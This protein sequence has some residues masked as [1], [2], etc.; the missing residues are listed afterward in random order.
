MHRIILSILFI[1]LFVQSYS[2]KVGLVLSGGGA[3]GISHI[4][5]IKVLEDHN[6]P[7][8]Y[9]AGT[10][11]GA[12]VAG[13]YAAGYSPEEMVK[14][15]ESDEFRLWSTGRLDKDE[16]YYFKKKDELPDWIK[17]DITKK[18]DKIK[19]IFPM[20]FIPERQMDFAFMQLMAQ[21]TAACEGDFDKMMVPFRCVATDIYHSTGLVLKQ[22]DLGE[23]IRASMTVPFVFKPIK[24]DGNVL[25]DGG[26]VNNFPAD[27]MIQEFNPD[28]IIGHKVSNIGAKDDMDDIVGQI[29][30]IITQKTNYS[31]PDSLGILL[32]SSLND[33]GLLDFQKV[34]YIYGKGVE[35]AIKS[36][37]SIE[38][39]IKRRVPVDSVSARRKEFNSKKPPFLFNNVQVEGVEDELNRKYIIESIKEKDKV[40]DLKDLRDAYFKL[41]T[42]EHIKS[43][44]PLAYFNQRT[45]FFDLHLKVEPRKPFDMDIGGHLSTSANTFG[46]FGVNYKTFRRFSLNFSS[47]IFFGRFYNSFM[48]GG[49]I[50]APSLTPFFLSSYFTLNS[51]DYLSTSA[52]LLF[53]DIRTSYVVQNETNFRFEAGY[54]YI[55]TGIIDFGFSFSKSDDKYYQTSIIET[56]D[57]LDKTTFNAFSSFIRV[58]KKNYDYKQYPTE[59]GRKMFL[60]RYIKGTEKFF[61]GSTAPV[62]QQSEQQQSYFQIQAFY[63]QYYKLNK[64]LSLGVLFEASFNNRKLLDN[65]TS[66]VIAAPAFQP[67]PNSKSMFIENFHANQYFAG[68]GKAVYKLSDY[69][70][71]RS[72]FYGFIPIQKFEIGGLNKA[73]YDDKIFKNIHFMGMAALVFNTQIGPLSLEVNYYDKPGDKWFASLNMGFMLFNKRGY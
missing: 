61:P 14:L 47:N 67:T 59:G 30:S 52:D 26:I 9:V 17:V 21:T 36:I 51:W 20:N 8:D 35:T 45:G 71:L 68:G 42:D 12:I 50:D 7:I 28:I 19:V 5:L 64:N 63:D 49:R 72:E 33:V 25:F 4:G 54:P 48:I 29:E 11:I 18:D 55:K 41:I 22:G 27:V 24:K 10:S 40:I 32:E 39:M 58:D 6:I 56:G 23:A 13:L 2:Q 70:H 60:F 65:Y 66:T 15:F 46:Y 44:Q 16:L 62:K 73:Y 57:E 37:D 53:S 31:I 1:F 69:F 38:D 34:Q 43:I 3:K